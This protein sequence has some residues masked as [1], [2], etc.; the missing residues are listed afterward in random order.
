MCC[1]TRLKTPFVGVIT[2]HLLTPIVFCILKCWKR[3]FDLIFVSKVLPV[4][5]VKVFFAR[6]TFLFDAVVN[7]RNNTSTFREPRF[8]DD[9]A[10]LTF[11]MST[12][13]YEILSLIVRNVLT[14]E[15]RSFQ[16]HGDKQLIAQVLPT[17]P[18]RAYVNNDCYDS[19][20]DLGSISYTDLLQRLFRVGFQILSS[21][22]GSYTVP[23]QEKSIIKNDP[24]QNNGQDTLVLQYTLART[25]TV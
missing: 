22:S 7:E 2:I 3:S 5:E 9:I 21:S 4:L 11:Q 10:P 16:L 12:Q 25:Q 13:R 18:D 20:A 6:N 23:K 24:Q 19:T 14:N 1:Q 8:I 15:A 17:A